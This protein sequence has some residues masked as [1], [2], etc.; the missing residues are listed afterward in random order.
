MSSEL[1]GIITVGVSL[2]GLMLVSFLW[3]LSSISSIERRLA[4]LEDMFEFF[5]KRLTRLEG[6]F[7]LTDKRL[8]KLEG[9][10]E[11]TILRKEAAEQ[12][13]D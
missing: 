9:M 5:D 2:G 6:M 4:R 7:E 10:F 1:I 12:K 11:F 3:T 13:P 8:A